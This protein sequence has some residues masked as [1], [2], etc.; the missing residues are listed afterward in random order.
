MEKMIMAVIPRDEA[1]KVL[2]ALINSGFSATFAETKG[3]MLRQ[4]QYTIF[5]AVKSKDVDQVCDLICNNCTVD[6]EINDDG[7]ARQ[8]LAEE[9]GSPKVGGAIVFIW[10]IRNTRIY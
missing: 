8:E 6:V 7:L 4:S 5:S 2:D 1:E 3:G 10:D 9:S